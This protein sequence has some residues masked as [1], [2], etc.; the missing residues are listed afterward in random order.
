VLALVD[1]FA[2]VIEAGLVVFA[3]NFYW[4]SGEIFRKAM[5]SKPN[6]G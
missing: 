5:D 2:G 4:R 1:V 3:K 6:P